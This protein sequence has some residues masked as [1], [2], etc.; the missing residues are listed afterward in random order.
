MYQQKKASLIMMMCEP[1]EV[2]LFT[3]VRYRC[4]LL[5]L[6]SQPVGVYNT[7][8]DKRLADCRNG[9]FVCR[10]GREHYLP[11]VIKSGIGLLV[12]ISIFDFL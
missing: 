1:I 5:R 7:E 3:G 2:Q 9:A 8:F 11:K 6:N 10:L 12:H 4:N